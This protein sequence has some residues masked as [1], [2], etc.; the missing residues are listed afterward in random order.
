ML[1]QVVAEAST[2]LQWQFKRWGV[3]FLIGS[4]VLFDTFSNGKILLNNMKKLNISPSQI[5]HIIISHEHF[6]HIGGLYH[7]LEKNNDVSV[8]ICKHFSQ[9]VKEKIQSYSCKLI[10]IE[11][12]QNITNSIMTTGEIQTNYK[13]NPL[14]EQAIIIMANEN[15]LLTGCAHPGIINILKKAEEL[16]QK[17]IST[18]IGGFHLIRASSNEVIDII[19]TFKSH[20][21]SRIYPCHCTRKPAIKLFKKYFSDNCMKI[22]FLSRVII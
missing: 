12:S 1:I 2:T 16:I 7:I 9:S 20:K 17:N 19:D 10:E 14:W 3:S 15:I 22:N 21:I 5:K 6:D 4:D 13:S 11:G 18:I 8:Y